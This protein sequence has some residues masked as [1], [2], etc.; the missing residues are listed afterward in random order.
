MR[1]NNV[2]QAWKIEHLDSPE[3]RSFYDRSIWESRNIKD[4]EILKR[5]MRAAIK[6]SSAVCVLVGTDTWRS[7]WVKYEIS[8][9]V[10][11]ERGLW[12]F[13]STASITSNGERQTR[14]DTIR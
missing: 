3:N 10:V 8:R 12:L 7:R 2:R 1:T 14:L 5:L 11:D 4:E 13:T 6:Y 9:A